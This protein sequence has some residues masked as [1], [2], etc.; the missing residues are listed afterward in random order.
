MKTYTDF[1]LSVFGG[2]IAH[3]KP[4]GSTE[5]GDEMSQSCL[6]VISLSPQSF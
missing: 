4:A 1:I 3:E 5:A 2:F 6:E